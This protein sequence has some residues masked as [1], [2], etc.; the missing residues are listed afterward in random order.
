MKDGAWRGV[1]TLKRSRRM[2]DG[3]LKHETGELV[4]S[5]RRA[6]TMDT[7]AAK[8]HWCVR[9]AAIVDAEV[10]GPELLVRLDLF[11]DA[12]VQAR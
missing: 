5:E 4:S 7:M 1:K 10:I 12:D 2:Q 6:D 9:P 8:V 3:R 11:T